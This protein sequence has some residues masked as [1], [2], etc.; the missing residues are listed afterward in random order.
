MNP[1]EW[2]V[3][4]WIAALCLFVVVVGLIAH[5]IRRDEAVSPLVMPTS[6]DAL[7]EA[8]RRASNG[9]SCHVVWCD[10][11]P[12]RSVHGWALCDEHYEEKVS[13]R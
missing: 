1:Y 9:R 5:A 10:T 3:G 12:T 7:S 11:P 2:G 6:P 4:E 13:A 8:P